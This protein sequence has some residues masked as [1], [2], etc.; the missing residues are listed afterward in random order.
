MFAEAFGFVFFYDGGFVNEGESDFTFD[1]YADNIGFGAR[2]L[3]MGSPLKLDY[4]IPLNHPNHLS[5]TPQFHFSFGT[6]Y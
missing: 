1:N 3:M 5:D 6:R 4:G 2:I